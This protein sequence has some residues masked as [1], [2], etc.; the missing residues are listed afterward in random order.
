[1]D[2]YGNF[3]GNVVP[4]RPGLKIPLTGVPTLPPT[5]PPPP[6]TGRPGEPGPPG[7][8]VGL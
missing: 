4:C 1:M 3:T 2:Y 5:E 6:P 8:Q 7:Q